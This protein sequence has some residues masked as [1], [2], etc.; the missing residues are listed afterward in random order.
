MTARD[1]S[2][3]L[4]EE[5]DRREK[6]LKQLT[7]E[8]ESFR[9]VLAILERPTPE[10]LNLVTH[11]ASRKREAGACPKHPNATFDAKGKCRLCQSEYMKQYLANKRAK[12]AAA[13]SATPP[14]VPP[15][16]RA[17]PPE[18]GTPLLVRCDE[19]GD[20]FHDAR[21]MG[22]HKTRTHFNS[23][24]ERRSTLNG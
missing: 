16:P 13:A 19:C 3:I 22:L 21:T 10:A 5:L 20:R 2:I 14:V 12:K 9:R 7:E 11:V 17:V 15:V 6:L 8:V 18:P 23:A 4:H 24:S 1:I